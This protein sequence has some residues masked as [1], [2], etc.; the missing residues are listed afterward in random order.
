MYTAELSCPK[1]FDTTTFQEPTDVFASVI[2]RVSP[3][4]ESIRNRILPPD[5]PE[6]FI[7]FFHFD[8]EEI[9]LS[10]YHSRILTMENSPVEINLWSLRRIKIRGLRT[11]DKEY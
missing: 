10:Q 3:D 8:I 11:A 1:L 6:R 7:P 5:K 2:F 9:F 4:V